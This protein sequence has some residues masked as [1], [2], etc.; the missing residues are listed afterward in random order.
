EAHLEPA[1]QTLLEAIEWEQKRCRE[2]RSFR[3]MELT[4]TSRGGTEPFV[5]SEADR[6]NEVVKRRTGAVK[7]LFLHPIED[8]KKLADRLAELALVHKDSG[9]AVLIFCRKLEDVEKV[10]DKLAKAKALKVERLTGTLRGLE[11]DRL[12]TEN[13]VFARFLPAGDLKC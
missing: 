9:R 5:L 6:A 4:A 3:V 12:A 13:G 7:Q 1:F 10:A 8:E 2:F 11:R